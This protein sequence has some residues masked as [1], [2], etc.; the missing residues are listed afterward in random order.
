VETIRFLLPLAKPYL[1]R[2]ALG[3][4][5]AP[6]STILALAIPGL[7]G[8]SVNLLKELPG[9]PD[10]SLAPILGLGALILAAAAGRGVLLFGVRMLVIGASRGF[11][12]DLRNRLFDH[13]QSLDAR[14]Y[15]R[16]RTGDLLSR[17]TSDVEATRAL[18]G[19]VVLYTANAA[20]TLLLA[21]PLMAS[22]DSLLTALVL[23][24]LCS[25]ALAVRRV[26][27]RVHEASRRA[28][29][30][31]AELGSFAQENFAGVRVV[32]SL[33]R[34]EAELDGFS[35]I[36]ARYLDRTMEAER[37]YSWM[38]PTV[39]AIG[40]S[41]AILLL[42]VGG[43]MILAGTFT[44]GGFVEFAGYAALL[45]WPMVSI[46][47]VLN[48]VHRGSA[49]VVRL[50]EI[51]A[52]QSQVAI[53]VPG[54]VPAPSVFDPPCAPELEIR[55][56]T[57][58]YDDRPVLRDVSLRVPAGSTVAIVGRTGAG[59]STLLSLIPRLWRVPDGAV[60]IDGR[61]ANSIPLDELRRAIGFV[62]QESFLFSRTIAEN[63]AFSADGEERE[64]SRL[65][66]EVRRWA[67][68]ARLDKD[69]DQF[70]LGY[71]EVVGERGVT[72]SGGQKQ[73]AA[74]ARALLKDPRILLLDDPLSAVDAATEEEILAN[75]RHA[76]R[77]RT[78]VLASHRVAG[79]RSADRIFVLDDGR[80]AEEGP[81]RDLLKLGG[82]YA[83][84]YR[85]QLLAEELEKL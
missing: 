65:D 8:R 3:I 82:I 32:R 33:A 15:G 72:L 20:F 35:R 29:E 60:F 42:L 19:P 13:L 34:E 79:V 37:L 30:T 5:L 68:F 39:A 4:L 64:A 6:L 46:G 10:A 76:A 22:V 63:I 18:A 41:S 58:A 47:W 48:Q 54:V 78:V 67:A 21:L 69:I 25:L 17:L 12:Y 83:D 56:L 57:F 62:P 9:N 50:R 44:I 28:Q 38:G 70:P 84:L 40:E 73:R 59:K 31:L 61:D 75:L 52:A 77:G 74:I 71:G 80:V 7:T 2:Y 23:A 45:I 11:E 16:A 43:R 36:S 51:L 85:R 26:G 49:S 81:H 53:E 27:P 55:S 1:R 14:F 66:E 24:P